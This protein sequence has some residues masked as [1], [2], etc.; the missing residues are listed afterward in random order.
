MV[1]HLIVDLPAS[2]GSVN[3]PSGFFQIPPEG[4]GYRLIGQLRDGK[5]PATLRG[6]A[7]ALL[8]RITGVWQTEA[9]RTG[10]DTKGVLLSVSSLYRN[11][12]LQQHLIQEGA[13][14]AQVSAH[15]SGL[16]MGF[17][18]NG[19][20]VIDGAERRAVGRH[21]ESFNPRYS[22][23]LLNVLEQLQSEGL[24]HVIVEKKWILD[25]SG[26]PSEVTSCYHVCVAPDWQPE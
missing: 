10:L 22:A 17:D 18:P 6:P 15:E 26:E 5:E 12:A 20:Y 16:A 3:P 7:Y 23:C 11:R 25:E 24:C 1:Q 9:E 19:Y 8:M 2:E 4:D 13:M 21:D 14:A